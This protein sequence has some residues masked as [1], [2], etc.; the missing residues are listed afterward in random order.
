MKKNLILTLAALTVSTVLF[1]TAAWSAPQTLNGVIS[2][3]MCAKNHMMPG[4]TD[5]QCVQEC[6]KAGSKYVLV[7]GSKVYTLSAKPTTIAPFAGK[8]VQV[9]GEVNGTALAIQTIHESAK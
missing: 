5:A 6:V 3:S 1:V 7:S 4:K 8:H 9:Q 2:D